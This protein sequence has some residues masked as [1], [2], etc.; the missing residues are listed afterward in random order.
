MRSRPAH[1]LLC[2]LWLLATPVMATAAPSPPL[3][4]VGQKLPDVVMAGQNGPHRSL[5]SYRGRPM[6]VNV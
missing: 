5:S 6:I 1:S 4:A 3:V 2:A